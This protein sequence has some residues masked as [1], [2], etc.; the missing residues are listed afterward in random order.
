MLVAGAKLAETARRYNDGHHYGRPYYPRDP[1]RYY[2]VALLLNDYDRYY[3]PRPYRYYYGSR[4][5]TRWVY[6][7]YID[8]RVRVRYCR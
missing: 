7:P 3:Y 1:Y 6:D 4:C 2:L 5:T 8:R